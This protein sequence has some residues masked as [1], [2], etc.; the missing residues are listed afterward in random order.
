MTKI[1]ALLVL[2]AAAACG[3]ATAEEGGRR[4]QEA[5]CEP[6]NGATAGTNCPTC[7]YYLDTTACE[8]PMCTNTPSV[9]DA[10]QL[11]TAGGVCTHTQEAVPCTASGGTKACYGTSTVPAR[12]GV[13]P[14]PAAKADDDSWDLGVG[15]VVVIV[16]LVLLAVGC[17]GA[18]LFQQVRPEG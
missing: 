16:L 6:A 15:G 9:V 2:T 11:K 10:A 17:C 3:R 7:P 5:L 8:P 4:S 18:V 1:K 13:A 12:A 14:A